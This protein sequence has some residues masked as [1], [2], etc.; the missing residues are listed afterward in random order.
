M[1]ERQQLV[2]RTRSN[3]WRPNPGIPKCVPGRECEIEN[4]DL[5]KA[6]NFKGWQIHH[7]LE[8]KLAEAFTETD[9][10]LVKMGMYFYRPPEELIYLTIV[11]HQRL[12]RSFNNYMKGRFG[13]LNH[14]YG[15][16]HTDETKN[17]LRGKIFSE[18]HRRKIGDRYYPRGKDSPLWK[19][20]HEV[21]KLRRKNK[22]LHCLV[23]Q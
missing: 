18:E 3:K 2:K 6:D 4:Y 21:C 8:E 11:E 12:H 22:G 14:F 19:G 20:G 17:K 16:K 23:E 5:A 13:E 7:R 15:K 1:K 10:A 9:I